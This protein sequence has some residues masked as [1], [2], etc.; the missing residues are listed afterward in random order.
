MSNEIRLQIE[1]LVKD[2]GSFRVVD[3][4]S[5]SVNAGEIFG[6]LG[7]NGAGKTTTLRMLAG[8]LKPTSG[9]IVIDKYAL[10]EDP[11]NAKRIT[12]YIPDRPYLYP[13]LTAVEFL[14]FICDIYKMPR[15]KALERIDCLLSE[16]KL[17]DR[18]QDLIENYSHGMKQ[19]LALCSAIIH[20]PLLLIVDEPM[21]GLDPHGSKL[22]KESFRKFASLGMAI[23]FSTH[24]LNVAEELVNRLAIIENGKIL[25][26]GT[27]EEI[28]NLSHSPEEDLEEIFLKITEAQI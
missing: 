5:L 14:T 9:R 7:V 10:N 24:S 20:E 15:K 2:F 26:M 13:R 16:F 21:V 8:V 28:K 25:K 12:G 6:F 27:L 1:N 4:I 23:F 17:T 11:V 3:N 18:K 22:L 19:R